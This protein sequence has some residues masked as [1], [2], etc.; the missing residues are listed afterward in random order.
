MMSRFWI[1]VS[2][3]RNWFQ[4]DP[5]LDWLNEYGP[6]K[7]ITKDGLSTLS[8]GT[9]PS[10][11]Q[12]FLTQRGNDWE[13]LQVEQL[14]KYSREKG[15]LVWYGPSGRL[16]TDAEW[17][18]WES[19]TQD[20]LK[21]YHV[22]IHPVLQWRSK[23]RKFGDMKL[24]FDWGYRGIPDVLI[25]PSVWEEISEF[26]FGIRT[27]TIHRHWQVL[28]WKWKT[29]HV[30]KDKTIP[31]HSRGSWGMIRM[32]CLLYQW[33]V[34]EMVEKKIRET[35]LTQWICGTNPDEWVPMR[36]IWEDS[37]VFIGGNVSL[38]G[39]DGAFWRFARE[40][41]EWR[42]RLWEEGSTWDPRK[43]P[44][45]HDSLRP[46]LRNQDD[47]GWGYVKQWIARMQGDVTQ[48]IFQTPS[49][50]P[51][52]KRRVEECSSTDLGWKSHHKRTKL[53]E[54]SIEK[55]VRWGKEPW[56]WGKELWK[57]VQIDNT[58][59]LWEV[60]LERIAWFDFE[61]I[62]RRLCF[63]EK[64]K[65]V[66][67]IP[68]E[69]IPPY[70]RNPSEWNYLPCLIS[71]H[72][73]QEGKWKAH[74][75]E[76]PSPT[77]E[78][79]LLL[80]QKWK[81]WV[82]EQQHQNGITTWMHWGHAE[83]TCIRQWYQERFI[84]KYI[85]LVE[86]M[87]GHYMVPFP[88]LSY[89]LKEWG[90]WLQTQG[91]ITPWKVGETERVYGEFSLKDKPRPFGMIPKGELGTNWVPYWVDVWEKGGYPENEEDEH[92]NRNRYVANDTWMTAQIYG[93]IRSAFPKKLSSS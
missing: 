30:T 3:M 79:A 38:Y 50:R 7:G 65:P 93:L 24:T 15:L 68:T 5:L 63:P 73:Y 81:Q 22:L 13:K 80:L 90:Q 44:V 75:W 85:D 36:T 57:G 45:Q 14:E 35:S 59:Q 70:I 23:E 34:S 62:P 48:I 42:L 6:L 8:S 33:M 28:D 19:R 20:A 88:M 41:L 32:Q 46:N 86:W 82:D 51:T 71:V 67:S 89:Q 39:R 17:D 25:H 87:K 56:D 37:N 60:P 83:Q 47:N 11:W 78:G 9:T 74:V 55:I 92:A 2:R 31:V 66:S 61:F 52:N 40:G 10:T 58:N 4:E 84:H 76:L 12:K 21:R 27:R 49:R 29:V 69:D 91:F 26:A 64:L 18:E 53:I 16:Q 72:I 1:S 77:W 43:I 54:N